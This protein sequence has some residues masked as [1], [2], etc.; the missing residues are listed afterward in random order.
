M[1]LAKKNASFESK[2]RGW[3]GKLWAKR[4]KELRVRNRSHQLNVYRYI[5]AHVSEGAWVW[6]W[7]KPSDIMG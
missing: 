6:R 2:A 4:G 1:G 7:V 3:Q 5:L